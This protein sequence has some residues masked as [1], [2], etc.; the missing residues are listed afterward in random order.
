M[1]DE[2]DGLAIRVVSYDSVLPGKSPILGGRPFKGNGPVKLQTSRR[3]SS[4]ELLTT[5]QDD[6]RTLEDIRDGD[7]I[8]GR[9]EKRNSQL[10]QLRTSSPLL[11]GPASPRFQGSASAA[12]PGQSSLHEQSR[13]LPSPPTLLH[14]EVSASPVL[15]ASVTDSPPAT[16]RLL[17]PELLPPDS[18]YGIR[19]DGTE[20]IS[21]N[22]LPSKN[23][24]YRVPSGTASLL[25]KGEEQNATIQALWKAEYGRL[26]AI[27]GRDGVDRNIAELN[28]DHQRSSSLDVTDGNH[29]HQLPPTIMLQP[30]PRPSFDA[31]W[32]ANSVRNSQSSF[33]RD[34]NTFDDASD[35]S[36]QK[37][38]SIMSSEGSSSSHTKRT[39]LYEPDLPTT[40]E[41]VRRVVENM[42]SNYLKAMESTARV[43][44]KTRTK[45]KPKAR[46]SLPTAPAAG[47][48]RPIVKPPKAARQSWHGNDV[49]VTAKGD[50]KKAKMKQDATQTPSPM[51]KPSTS[52]SSV[53]SKASLQRA[54][55]LTL[56]ALIPKIPPSEMVIGSG[57]LPVYQNHTPAQ[58]ALLSSFTKETPEFI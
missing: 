34:S 22:A 24:R 5:T 1:A 19:S 4:G 17:P 53:K 25:T 11:A 45:R 37:P 16:P 20:H 9:K 35:Y 54:D 29:N 32:T 51:L 15:A 58:H 52:R 23:T 27:Y 31:G 10:S 40:R 56:G 2:S 26:V 6:Q 12:T 47:S 28:R 46:I 21:A 38:S 14:S 8:V 7:Y 3:L 48:S 39:S 33:I 49:Q 55:S 57:S 43:T 30:L 36:S 42:R 50:R 44:D 13:W 41:D 18:G